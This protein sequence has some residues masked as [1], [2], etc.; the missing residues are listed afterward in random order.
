MPEKLREIHAYS[1]RIMEIR[2][3]VF[4]QKLKSL[5]KYHNLK[6]KLFV[7]QKG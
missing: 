6:S 2:E 3:F 1:E 5:P 7:R 4:Q